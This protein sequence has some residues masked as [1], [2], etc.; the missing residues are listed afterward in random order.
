MKHL[1]LLISFI[2]FC[3]WA[4]PQNQ[5]AVQAK[6]SYK[7]EPISQTPEQKFVSENFPFLHMADWKP[8]MRFMVEPDYLGVSSRLDI[9]PYKAKSCS[10]FDK[11]LQK[12]YE[13][14]IFTVVE[15]E[16]RL[17]KCPK[18]KCT[19]TYVILDCE[20]VKFEFEYIGSIDENRE[21]EIPVDI[22]NLVWLDE[23]DK[24][25][26]LLMDKELFILT[27]RWMKEK[28][29]SRGTVDFCKKY[30]PI[31]IVNIGL[32]NSDGPV[33]MVFKT[34]TG[35]EYFINVRF[36][37]T[38]QGSGVF[39]ADFSKTFSFTSPHDK[40]PEISDEIWSLIQ[41][42]KV[43]V[44]M[45]REECELAWGEPEDINSSVYGTARHE[46]WVYSSSKYLYFEEGKLKT[47]QN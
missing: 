3:L 1:T 39:G 46:Q 7:E 9:E 40:Y 14:K 42:G 17:V 34:E 15:L 24:A 22:D 23:I 31:I 10:Y 2:C 41:D 13:W 19:R 28:E 29:G 47:I 4:Y 37:G 36:S 21:S 43:R 20:G 32:G 38:N 12:D 30:V 33:K 25:K 6:S 35:E 45:T 44:G 18:G 11:P 8:G 5:Y 16:E 26:E 27:D